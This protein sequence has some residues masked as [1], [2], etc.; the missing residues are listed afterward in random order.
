[1]TLRQRM[2]FSIQVLKSIFSTFRFGVNLYALLK[3]VKNLNNTFINDGYN[4]ISYATLYKETLLVIDKLKNFPS[5]HISQKVVLIADNSF[6]FIQYLFALSALSREVIII[7]PHLAEGQLEKIL[8]NYSANLIITDNSV[9]I[10]NI[11][12]QLIVYSFAEINAFP[13]SKS[14][15]KLKRN[16]GK[17]T[18]LST[19]SSNMATAIE[20][21]LEVTKIW[22]PFIELVSKLSLLDYSSSQITVPFYHGYGLASLILAL[23]LKH[24][25]YFSSHF[26]SKL[27]VHSINNNRID[28]L[29]VIPSMI[30][31]LIDIDAYALG[32]CKCI[33]SG[34]DKLEPQWTSYVINQ[35]NKTKIFNLYGTTELG[36]CSIAA[37][38]DLMMANDTIGRFLKG[39][40]YNLEADHELKV[41][42]SWMQDHDNSLY[43]STGDFIRQDD[44]GLLYYLGRINNSLNI[45][46]EIVNCNELEKTIA[47]YPSIMKT[48]VVGHK[49]ENLITELRLEATLKNDVYFNETDFKNWLHE[50]LPKYLQPKSIHYKN[51]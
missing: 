26:N 12:L 1:M 14:I 43:I 46:G 38:D 15:R 29:V 9:Q 7:N 17:I 27:I 21:K 3:S 22:N 34:A 10:K 13:I 4:K 5:N 18:I 24:D 28:C 39:I 37:H 44:T 35:Y 49:N 23:F 16:Q 20:R 31:K 11:D 45:G 6:N 47:V 2:S 30:G 42:C 36:I 41:K 8:S 40:K 19:G 33:I 48:K 32:N 50:T 25:I 51:N